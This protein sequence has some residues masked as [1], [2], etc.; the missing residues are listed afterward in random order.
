MSTSLMYHAFGATTYDYFKTEYSHGAIYFHLSKK[1][2][3]QR[4]VVCRSRNVTREGVEIY[5]LHA[6]PI[7]GKS[8]FLVLHLHILRC[9]DC[10][11]L[12]QDSRDVADPRKSY[13]RPFARYVLDL[14]RHMTM[15]AIARHLRVGWDLVKEIIKENLQRRAKRRSWRKVRRIAIDE[16]AIRKGRHYMTVVLDLDTGQVLYTAEGNDHTSLK[17]FFSRLRKAR[18]KLEAIAVD[19]GK[20]YIKAI[21]LYAPKDVIVVHDRYHVVSNMNDV[22]SDV[23][24]DEQ[25]RLEE[26]GKNV[27][28]GSR[29]LLLYAKEKLADMPEKQSR[30]DALLAINETLSKVYILKEDLRLFWSQPSKDKAI[31]FVESWI[32][33]AKAMGNRHVTRFAKTIERRMEQVLAWYDCTITT[34]PLEGLNNKIKTFKRAAYGYRDMVFFGLRL[35]FLHETK[36]QLT[37]V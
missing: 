18:A 8:V 36:L 4:C 20:G 7:G 3:R 15:V 30:L 32:V 28:K 19:M 10:G 29:Y 5:P 27:I 25:N 16:I 21:E 37:G 6:L 11:T 14:S 13:T 35:M 1:Q 34:G 26:E 12:R 31:E 9:K 23:R 33:E 2:H 17:S 24:R 22:V